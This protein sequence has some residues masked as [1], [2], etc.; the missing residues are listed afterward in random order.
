M[1][2]LQRRPFLHASKS[3]GDGGRYRVSEEGFE[4]ALEGERLKQ[5]RKIPDT[6]CSGT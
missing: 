2:A 5:L 3:M 1:G 6:C 4:Q